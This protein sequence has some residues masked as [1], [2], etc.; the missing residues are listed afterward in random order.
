MRVI[1]DANGILNPA[2]LRGEDHDEGRKVEFDGK[3]VQVNG[4][5]YGADN[6]F[7]KFAILL[8]Q[9]NVAPRDCVCVWDG[10]NAKEFRRGRYLPTYKTGKDKA[11]EVSVELN[12]ARAI[13]NKKL[14]DL[15]VASAVCNG[16][17]ADD[18]IAFLVKNLR[19]QHTTVVTG[20]GDLSILK[21]DNTQVLKSGSPVWE[22]FT[23]DKNPFGGFPH[24]FITLYKA[25][26]GDQGDKIPGAKG[27][28]DAAWVDLVRT[29]GLEGIA[30]LQ[31]LVETGKIGRLKEDLADFPRL[32][33]ILDAEQMV[34]ASWKC[35][36]LYPDEVN[37][38]HRPLVI[39]PGLVAQWGASDDQES[40]LR[41]YYGMKKLVGP[42]TLAAM[43]EHFA[44]HL[45]RSGGFVALDVETSSSDESDDWLALTRKRGGD[46][47]IDVLG[48]N[49]TSLQLTYGDNGQYTV[50]LPVDNVET[51]TDK[52]LTVDDVRG[53]C[54]MIPQDMFTVIQNRSFEFNVLHR[55]WGEKWKDNGWAGF[56]PNA[57]DTKLEAS[58]VNEN[59]PTGLKDR[60]KLNFGYEQVDYKTVTQ[61]RRMNQM[62]AREVFDYGCD[63]TICTSASHTYYRLVMEMEHTWQVYLDVELLPEYL[64]SLAFTQGVR[65]SKQRLRELEE[66]DDK[67]YTDNWLI[68][69]DYLLSLGWEG[70]VCPVYDSITPAAI[71]EAVLICTGS[72]F[73][74][75]NRRLDK[76]V[77]DMLDEF[78]GEGC[79]SVHEIAAI[80]RAGDVGALNR[81]VASHYD[82]EPK[83]NFNS[84]K[85]IGRLLYQ[86]VG[87]TPRIFNPLTEKER[88]NEE[89]RT[90]FYKI[91][92]YQDD[93]SKV[94]VTEEDR[95]VWAKKASTDD[96]AVQMALILD[97]L[98]EQQRSILNAYCAIKTVQTR[99][100]LYYGNYQV[101]QHW[102]DGRIHSSMNQCE[103]VTRRYSSSKPN[104]TAM[105]KRGEG[106]KFR[107]IILPHH[108][109]AVVA[110][111][112]F[113]GQEMVLMAELSGDEKLTACYV[114]DNRLHPHVLLAVEAAPLMWDGETPSYERIQQM[115]KL[116]HE[117]PDYQRAKTLYEDSKTVNFATQYDAQAPTVALKL[118]STP[119]KAQKFIDAKGR[120]FPRIDEWKERCREFAEE[121]GYNLTLMGA[122]R[123]LAEALASDNKWDVMRAGRQGPNFEDQGS[124]AEMTKM[125]MGRMVKRK[126]FD[127]SKYD[128]Q[129]IAPIH[130]EVVFSVHRDDAVAL[131][132]EVHACMV[133]NYA[134]M[135]IPIESSV[136]IGKTFGHQ[137]EC[138]DLVNEE[139]INA[140]LAKIFGEE[141]AVA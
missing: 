64:T 136:S 87:I 38:P 58:Y 101:L 135:K 2:L 106:V 74:T 67:V 14:K 42:Q 56:I 29:F 120:T 24:Q 66:A 19:D 12:K 3:W 82:G 26:V 117:D 127:G 49:L 108:K 20:D 16:M 91:K 94:E 140:A 31:Q 32:Q 50:Y 72:E 103:A 116:P 6:F 93:P 65:I 89:M 25:I 44:H 40:D 109:D 85:Q 52:N 133:Q 39:T 1:I 83:L 68:L 23:C 54:E 124:A 30:V 81:K 9:L 63:D 139:R 59:L 86:A 21:D 132:R 43:R 98:N 41:R 61:G 62:T 22:E 125:A 95:A 105:P 10:P 8:K 78:D 113:I 122:R 11:P 79:D 96:D 128:A 80:V 76:V 130:D 84:P 123:H 119:E 69:R 88:A 48:H 107:E 33:K 47:G 27:F 35:A 28:G 97:P 138:G 53:V 90:S 36:L 73:T 55:A 121:H 104:L 17:E 5:E 77:D 75:R 13:V 115:R 60:S 114:G 34:Y 134:G 4:A 141:L 126:L 51:E 37:T 100:N 46:G 131:I 137:I 118:K 7:E 129:F 102:S 18:V 112:D 71:K 45:P 111:L 57:L 110:S 15:G 99:R 70:T 92:K